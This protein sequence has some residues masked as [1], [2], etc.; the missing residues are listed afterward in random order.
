MMHEPA[1]IKGPILCHLEESDRL[2]NFATYTLD[3]VE[4]LLLVVSHSPG[5]QAFEVSQLREWKQKALQ[6]GG[7][8]LA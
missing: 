6:V 8:A 7:I 5:Q 3:N 4:L 1:R 2:Q